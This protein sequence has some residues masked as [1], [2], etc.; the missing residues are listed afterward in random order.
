MASRKFSDAIEVMC[1]SITRPKISILRFTWKDYGNP[2][3]DVWLPV[4]GDLSNVKTYNQNGR[5]INF[6]PFENKLSLPST[7]SIEF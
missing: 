6:K 2:R 4:N 3:M 5:L 1:G 7:S